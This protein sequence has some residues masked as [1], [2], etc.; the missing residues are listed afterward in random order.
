MKMQKGFTLIEIMTVLFILSLLAFMSYRG[1]GA[2]LDTRQHVAMETKKW[3]QLS[4]FFL[5][6]E[7]D[8]LLAAPWPGRQSSSP[9]AAWQGEKGESDEIPLLTF[10]RFASSG[11][12]DLPRRV[13]YTLNAQQEIELW[14]WPGMDN[15]SSTQPTRYTLLKNVVHFKLQYLNDE[16]IW[17]DSWPDELNSPAIPRALKL[18]I[19]LLSGEHISRLFSLKS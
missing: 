15:A 18:R 9:V 1:L 8:L 2:V 3:Q 5:R 19:V 11:D 14:L 13:A 6:F 4:A 16:K 7:Q 12:V 17:R 10:S